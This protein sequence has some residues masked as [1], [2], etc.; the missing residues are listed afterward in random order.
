MKCCCYYDIS[1][2]N[3]STVKPHSYPISKNQLPD[4]LSVKGSNLYS[5]LSAKPDKKL[6]IYAEKRRFG[7]YGS[8]DFSPYTKCGIYYVYFYTEKCLCSNGFELIFDLTL[9]N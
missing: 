1:S 6:A 8:N 4:A 9:Y 2:I 3:P 5:V 7:F